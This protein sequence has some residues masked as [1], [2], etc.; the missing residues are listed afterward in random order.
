MEPAKDKPIRL[1]S[2]PQPDLDGE[3][4]PDKAWFRA[5]LDSARAEIAAL[6]N[7][8]GAHIQRLEPKPGETFLVR[9]PKDMNPDGA[10]FLVA[11]FRDNFPELKFIVA[12]HTVSIGVYQGSAMLPAGEEGL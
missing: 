11:Y 9:M 8:N 4:G 2:G 5:E 1:S 3:A 12:D 10:Q 6:R 7:L